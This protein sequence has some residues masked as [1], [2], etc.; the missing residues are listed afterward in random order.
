MSPPEDAKHKLGFITS[1]TILLHKRAKLN[2]NEVYFKKLLD[3]LFF[4][5]EKT[6]NFPETDVN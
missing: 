5:C 3:S 4:K 2:F 1:F 6:P